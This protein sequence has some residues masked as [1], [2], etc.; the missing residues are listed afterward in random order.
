MSELA[1][2]RAL[3]LVMMDLAFAFAN[4]RTWLRNRFRVNKC[5]PYADCVVI[6]AGREHTL[7]AGVP[8]HRIDTAFPV[9]RKDF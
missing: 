3:L 6:R 7:L 1:G 2:M 8:C 9:S 4:G 5:F